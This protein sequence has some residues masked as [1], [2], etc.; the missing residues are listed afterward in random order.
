MPKAALKGKFA[1]PKSQ[2][3]REIND[4]IVDAILTDLRSSDKNMNNLLILDDVIKDITQSRRLSHVFLNRRHITH[5]A[6]KEGC[7]G[8]SV[9]IISQVYNLLP[10][11]FRKAC[12]NVVL[13]KTENK[14]ELR[15]IMDELMY[16]LDQD[17][18]KQILD[19]AW[20]NKYG[21]L[22]IKTGQPPDKKYYDKFD[23]IK[24]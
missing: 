2:Q 5:D 11:Q 9:M 8:L 24:I 22:L 21:F 17:Q 1:V 6:E 16:D 10:L 4:E 18:A 7:G 13:F 20:R 19:R 14:S 15:F 3:F 23:L 12:D